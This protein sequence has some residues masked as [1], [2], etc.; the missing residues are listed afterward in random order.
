MDKKIVAAIYEIEKEIGSGGGGIVYLGKHLRLNKPVVLKAD[1]RTL[2]SKP[3]L[4]RRE[5]D[6]LKDL[7]HTYIPQVYDFIE[8]NGTVYTVMDYIEGES[9]DKPL[10]R[11][12]RFSQA[13]VIKW[14]KQLLEGLVYLHTRPPHGILHADI[15]PANIML[16]PEG[17][18]CLIDFNIALAL[19]EEGAVRV[20]FSHGYASPEH[21]G[22]DYTKTVNT[23]QNSYIETQLPQD[24]ETA[25]PNQSGSYTNNKKSILLDV[26]SDIY[27]LGA[28][29]YHLF[30][31]NRPNQSAVDVTPMQ[32]DN[33]ST[34]IIQIISKAMA[35]NPDERFQSAKEML[36]SFNNLY[37]NDIRTKKHKK[38][39]IIAACILSVMFI[40]GGFITFVGLK[41]MEQTQKIYTLAEYA[42]NSLQSGDIEK[43]I[44]LSL[45]ALP[46]KDIFTPDYLPQAQKA[47][48]DAL[49]VYDLSDGFKNY[50]L[51]NLNSEPL[52]V[53]MS[54]NGQRLAVLYAYEF[55]IF[56]ISSGEQIAKLP[57]QNSAL[58]DIIFINDDLIAYAGKNGVEVYNLTENKILWTGEPATQLTIS[59]D[60]TKLAAIYKD[61]SNAIIYN[62][63]DGKQIKIVDFSGKKHNIP[64]NDI[65]A[66]ANNDLFCLNNTGSMLASSFSDGAL[67]I[68]DLENPQN[69]III[70]ENSQYSSFSGGFYKDY[71]TFS[72]S[73]TNDTLFSIIDLENFMQTGA[74]SSTQPFITYTDE[75]GVFIANEDVLV[76][77][78]P[79]TG[80]QTEVA[81]TEGNIITD[82]YKSND[83][84]IVT[85]DNN[86]WWIFDS[87]ANCI[88]KEKSDNTVD[89]INISK[90]FATIGSL[91]SPNLT[92]MQIQNHE[93]CEIFS[94]D[95]AFAH[96][97]ARISADYKTVMLYNYQQ[98]RL[99]NIDGTIITEFK[100]PNSE[101]IYDQQ[102]NKIGSYLEVIYY[103]G[104]I[105]QYSVT[106]GELIA[107][108]KGK[109]PDKTLYEEFYTDNLKITAPLHETPVAYDKKTGEKIKELEKNAYLT[110]VTQLEEYVITEYISSEGLRYGLILDENCE[111]LAYL[112]YLCDIVG[113][114]LVFDYPSGN[115]R[116]SRFYSIDE[117]IALAK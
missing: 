105:K 17:N 28:T 16:T 65:L 76:K 113:D 30:T 29:L 51:I 54:P 41:R 92:V 39:E 95:A 26:R 15:K 62:V 50:G 88:G 111:T 79:V 106:N 43:A 96:D 115:L 5:V 110:Y 14:A 4:L 10:N 53:E 52:K 109:K 6:A 31:G 82:F 1:R 7:H 117:L 58:S 23:T 13:Q 55:V 98:C 66:D 61:S 24:L 69:D 63:S 25:L 19:K 20:G 91:N 100:F 22:L 45:Q 21:Y 116:E 73:A 89:F 57:A 104:T 3:E 86:T 35:P 87:G 2:S 101:Q 74:F 34:Q 71:F 72:C 38:R 40:L 78:H 49:N 75:N 18:I 37:K 12:E 48:T 94:Y 102:Y 11:G 33:L 84:T 85:T 36:D 56:D 90:D 42:Q 70:F 108:Q 107:E 46:E 64:I 67:M 80:E 103:D 114:K 8:E 47:L 83:Y 68:Y 112:P 81:Y 59:G 77:I 60:K 99:Y 32:G 93:N 44:S 27:S 9:L 97:E